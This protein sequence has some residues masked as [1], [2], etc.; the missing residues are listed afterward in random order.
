MRSFIYGSEKA[1]ED[2]L[3]GS[4]FPPKGDWYFPEF[5]EQRKATKS[6]LDPFIFRLIITIIIGHRYQWLTNYSPLISDIKLFTF[7]WK[8]FS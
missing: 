6:V 7:V 8:E 1:F 4:T 3:R 5:V 2:R